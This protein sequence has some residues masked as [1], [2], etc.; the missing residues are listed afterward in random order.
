MHCIMLHV[1]TAV[2][3]H[4]E[5]LLENKRFKLVL[6]EKNASIPLMLTEKNR[7]S[8]F[9]IVG[10]QMQHIHHINK[11]LNCSKLDILFIIYT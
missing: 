7:M 11:A 2:L 4:M 9:F 8:Y 5:E 1:L 6:K 3:H 10:G